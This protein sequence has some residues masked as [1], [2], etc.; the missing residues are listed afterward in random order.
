MECALNLNVSGSACT[1]T[2]KFHTWVAQRGAAESIDVDKNIIN[3][4]K[5]L[6][7]PEASKIAYLK[8][9]DPVNE[10]Q[11]PSAPASTSGEQQHKKKY[12]CIEDEWGRFKRSTLLQKCVPKSHTKVIQSTSNSNLE[13]S[14]KP[15]VMRLLKF[16]KM[17]EFMSK[18]PWANMSFSVNEGMIQRLIA[19]HLSLIVGVSYWKDEKAALYRIIDSI[20]DMSNI[21]NVVWVTNRQQGKTS[22]LA[23]FLAVLSLLSPTG[24]NLVCVYSTSLDRA[25]ELCRAAKKY[26]YWAIHDKGCQLFFESIG[27]VIPSLVQDNERAYAVRS[28]YNTVNTVIA[29][30]KNPDSCRGDAPKA[31]IFDEIGFVTG[32]FWYKFAYPLLQV[33]KR[34]FTC[35][36]TPPPSSSFFSVFIENIL[37][38]NKA[39]DFFF[40]L[41]NHSLVCINCQTTGNAEKCVHKLGLVPPWK[42]L[43]RFTQMKKLVPAKRMGDY[44]A[45]VYG[46]LQPDGGRYFPAKL[47][48]TCIVNRKVIEKNIIVKEN[49][50]VYVAVDPASHFRSTMGLAA[51]TYTEDGRIIILGLSAVP[52]QKCEMIQ[53][54]MVIQGFIERLS[55]HPW[56]TSF[57]ARNMRLIPIIECNNNEIVASTILVGIRAS[58]NMCG[59]TVLMP[60]T[61]DYFQGNITEN[62]GIWTTDVNKLAAIQCLYAAMMDGRVYFVKR[63]ITVGEIHRLNSRDPSYESQRALLATQLK[64]FRDEPNGKISG[65]TQ[66]DEDDLAISVLMAFYWS[67]CIRATSR[68]TG[69]YV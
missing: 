53:I 51:I 6:K 20:N 46:V 68:L 43:L 3:K 9:I 13:N 57:N 67:F 62:L 14:V 42:S 47:V 19:S 2:C 34:V 26:I 37:D 64:N 10:I 15:G 65:K 60:F 24:G 69:G 11:E 5:T 31:A 1:C 50:V 27:F 22:T 55:R 17:I 39:G 18:A 44:Q 58:A 56:F 52:V 38:R 66:N 41:I 35:A 7:L 21:Q 29:R 61:R 45:E 49:A 48:D 40:L 16:V 4:C 59:Y 28:Q 25:Q 8:S 12:R 32:D 63:G 36:T 23:K 54:Q 33:G 30:P